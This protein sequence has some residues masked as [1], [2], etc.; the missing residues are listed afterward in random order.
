MGGPGRGGGLGKGRSGGRGLGDGRGG[1]RGLNAQQG[2][3]RG[4]IE[5]DCAC[6]QCGFRER[7]VVGRPCVQRKCPKCGHRMMRKEGEPEGRD[8]VTD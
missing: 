3:G 2:P 4:G 5:A 7:H 6:P 8:Q 1:G